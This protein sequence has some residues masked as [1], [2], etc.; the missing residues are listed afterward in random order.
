MPS[1]SD[2]TAFTG[3]FEV[4]RPAISSL[5]FDSIAAH[6][7]SLF[8]IAARDRPELVLKG[9]VVLVSERRFMFVGS[10]WITQTTALVR[11]GLTIR[12]Y[13]LHDPAA[14]Y[15]ILVQA[16]GRALEEAQALAQELRRARDQLRESN[17]DLERKVE[18][19]VTELKQRQ[20][21]LQEARELADTANRAKSQFMASM[22]HELRTPL[23][24][25]IGYSEMLLEEVQALGQ[26]GFVPDLGKICG[27]GKH[28]LVLINNILD[29][30]KI[31]AGKMDV[32][33]ESFAVGDLLSDVQ[34]TLQPLIAKNHN[35][36]EMDIEPD[37]GGMQSDQT[38]IRQ[39][40]FNL[41]SNASKFARDG[42]ITLRS[43]R[44]A[45]DYG[46]DWLEFRV[47]DTGIGMTA[48]QTAKLFQAF[49]QADASTA[50]N[51]GGSGLG[52]AITK[53]FSRL[54][55]GDVTVESE[56]GRGSTF[57]MT[58]PTACP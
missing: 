5:D 14:D 57:T 16:Q 47:S 1:F 22:S 23:N 27:A 36:L 7:G 43:R 12:D 20:T 26:E 15:L 39:N 30:S 48:E 50:R 45:G 33:V 54:L 3:S 53:H 38:K 37:L 17:A 8:M 18:D 28:L 41:L 19:R 52:L 31:E 9:Q 34:A 24:A 25:I 49:A 55:G 2:G 29:L 51:Y 40:L 10:P 13:A 35:R 44:L 11:L 32:F 4:R 56:Y 46:A 21:E 58:L 6:Q 42:L